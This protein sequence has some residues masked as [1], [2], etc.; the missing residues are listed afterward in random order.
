M[1]DDSPRARR[2]LQV[3]LA[4][5]ALI[6]IAVLLLPVVV[7][8]VKRAE[9]EQIC[10]NNQRQIVLAA[11][12]YDP[13]NGHWPCRPTDAQGAPA[14]DANIDNFCTAAASLEWLLINER[15]YL[16]KQAFCCPSA[17]PSFDSL[18]DPS[19]TMTYAAGISAWGA[20]HRAK[21]P[22][23]PGGMS[24]AYDWSAPANASSTRIVLADRALA[25][26]AR[27]I[28]TAADGHAVFIPADPGTHPAR[29]QVT[30]DLAGTPE[31]VVASIPSSDPP[32]DI[33]DDL[34]DGG[35]MMVPGGGSAT[36]AW[37]R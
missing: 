23:G 7:G 17:G 33:Y 19:P 11:L 31:G 34:D 27:V 28:A 24:Y 13:D 22:G 9:R 12:V 1:N 15:K 6:V 18:N 32:D 29:A 16:P 14:Q 21:E 5:F 4:V 20:H 26:G 35:A 36:R 2:V 30:C 3:L 8:A 37:L 10:I 25:H